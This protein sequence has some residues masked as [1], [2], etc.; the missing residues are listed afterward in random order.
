MEAG[1]PRQREPSPGHR[2]HSLLGRPYGLPARCSKIPQERFLP[3]RPSPEAGLRVA[4]TTGELNTRLPQ[5][6][7]P[8][9]VPGPITL[10]SVPPEAGSGFVCVCVWV[11][12]GG[13]GGP[14]G[15]APVPQPAEV[16]LT[17][18]T[19][20]WEPLAKL[21]P[22]PTCTSPWAS[23][24]SKNPQAHLAHHVGEEARQKA[25]KPRKSG[26][27]GGAGD[28]A[29]TPGG[30]APGGRSPGFPVQSP[31][32]TPRCRAPLPA[33]EPP[34]SRGQK[35][36]ASRWARQL[37]QAPL[38]SCPQVGVC[39]GGSQPDPIWMPGPAS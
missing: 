38:P 26:K 6:Q 7:S 37:G 12:V 34:G 32:A 17:L 27:L 11:R 29:S 21:A 3:R 14:W 33:T 23:V 4:A 1:R 9:F 36:Q 13:E 20:G 2:P 28:A 25:G 35:S 31:V 5:S 15:A 24:P 8:G 22:G 16:R 39:G 18:G 19:V 30:P 10:R